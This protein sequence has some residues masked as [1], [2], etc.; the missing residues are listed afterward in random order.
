MVDY[1]VLENAGPASLGF[2]GWTLRRYL[3]PFRPRDPNWTD[4]AL[5][6]G[7]VP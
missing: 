5:R 1:W 6:T 7:R 3:R 4:A 2:Q